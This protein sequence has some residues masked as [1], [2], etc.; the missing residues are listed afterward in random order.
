MDAGYTEFLAF[1]GVTIAWM[2]VMYV[3]AKL[4]GE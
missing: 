1:L 3:V 4:K 2:A